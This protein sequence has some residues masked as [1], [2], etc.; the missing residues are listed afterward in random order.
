[1][2]SSPASEFN[3]FAFSIW[4][5]LLLTPRT[6]TP[7]SRTTRRIGPPIPQPTSTT[8]MPSRSSSLSI[9]SRWCRILD[10]SRLSR[11]D[12]GAK[13]K[14]SPQPKTMNSPQRS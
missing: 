1:M 4:I 9:I 11:G 13:C 7:A 5:S 12:R 3:D 14:D 6:L 2:W 8:A 10:S